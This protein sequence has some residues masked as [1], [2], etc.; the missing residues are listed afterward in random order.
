MPGGLIVSK[1]IGLSKFKKRIPRRRRGA[2][3]R[4]IKRV[5]GPRDIQ[6]HAGQNP[7]AVGGNAQ[8]YF[9][10]ISTAGLETDLLGLIRQGDSEN[11]RTGNTIA[12][13]DI[14]VKCTFFVGDNNNLMRVLL[15]QSEQ[16]TGPFTPLA[17]AGIS[18][19]SVVSKK[20]GF[21]TVIRALYADK[22]LMMTVG[23]RSQAMFYK[24]IHFK[25]PLIVRYAQDANN[26]NNV[27]FYLFCASD[28]AAAAHPFMQW[29]N[30]KV[31]FSNA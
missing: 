2:L 1:G 29:I 31:Y 9:A 14:E 7:A 15:Y 17:T 18:Y 19:N 25:R 10:G 21:G 11:D 23:E 5:A 27:K 16:S 24:K 3:V 22:L 26:S 4:M 20:S 12:V 6:M 8:N 13:T 30:Y 28:S